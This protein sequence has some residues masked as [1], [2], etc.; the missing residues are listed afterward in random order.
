LRL[1]GARVGI[2]Q[3]IE[4]CCAIYCTELI[5]DIGKHR[6]EYNI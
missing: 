2:V 4:N 6:D 3:S 5:V 1:L